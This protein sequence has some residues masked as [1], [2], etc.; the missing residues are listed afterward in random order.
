[1]NQRTIKFRCWDGKRFLEPNS[2]MGNY[3]DLYFEG[4]LGIFEDT[5]CVFQQFTGLLD[6][7]GKEIYEGDILRRKKDGEK[8]T[9]Y[10]VVEYRN[11]SF[12]GSTRPGFNHYLTARDWGCCD[13]DGGGYD[14]VIGNVF[15]NKDL[16]K[17]RN[18][19]KV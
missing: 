8:Y 18:S 10:I 17:G 2:W 3:D 4:F 15:E 14:L 19:D 7:E 6:S 12:G 13:Y 16:L 9:F 5:D 11:G 1:M